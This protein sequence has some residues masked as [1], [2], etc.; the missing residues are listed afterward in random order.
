LIPRELRQF[1]AIPNH[2]AEGMH[3]VSVVVGSLDDEPGQHANGHIFVRSKVS[4]FE[5]NDRLPQFATTPYDDL[6]EDHVRWNSIRQGSALFE[7]N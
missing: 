7:S 2:Q 1:D 3:F 5:I 6:S 4:R